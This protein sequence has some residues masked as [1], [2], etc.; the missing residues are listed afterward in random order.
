MLVG[1]K[2][3]A[4]ILMRQYVLMKNITVRYRKVDLNLVK[5]YGYLDILKDTSYLF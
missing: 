4:K 5:I 2:K 1:M 3:Y